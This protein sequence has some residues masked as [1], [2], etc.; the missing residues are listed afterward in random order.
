M[1]FSRRSSAAGQLQDQRLVG[2]GMALKSKLSRLL[3]AF[4]APLDH[5]AL[6]VDQSSSASL[7]R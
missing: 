7:N 5:A 4:D 6:A 1:R 2:E 3:V